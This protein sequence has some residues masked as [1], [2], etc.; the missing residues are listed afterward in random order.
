MIAGGTPPYRIS[1]NNG[2]NQRVLTNLLPGQYTAVVSDYAWNGVADYTATTTCSIAEIQVDCFAGASFSEFTVTKTPTPT[3]TQTPTNTP[4][5][6]VTPS[7]PAE[8]C[9]INVPYYVSSNYSTPIGL[10][11]NQ[12]NNSLYICNFG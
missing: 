9:T 11:Y 8:T 4:T 2:S 3:P 10:K 7:T 5:P 6:T 1:W 12:S